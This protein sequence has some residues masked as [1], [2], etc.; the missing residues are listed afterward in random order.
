MLEAPGTGVPG[1]PPFVPLASLTGEALGALKSFEVGLRCIDS[2][3]ACIQGLAAAFVHAANTPAVYHFIAAI[4][5][6]IAEAA[7]AAAAAPAA[8]AAAAAAASSTTAAGGGSAQLVLLLYMLNDVLQRC[9]SCGVPFLLQLCC[10]PLQ[11]ICRA[12]A[13]AAAAD[14]DE[15]SRVISILRQRGTF[16]GPQI[17]DALL[18][19]LRGQQVDVPPVPRHLLLL[20]PHQQQHQHQQ[21][22]QQQQQRVAGA[23]PAEQADGRQVR[24]PQTLDGYRLHFPAAADAAAAAAAEAATPTTPE[25]AAFQQQL[26]RTLALVKDCTLTIKDAL[27]SRKRQSA[28]VAEL[29]QTLQRLAEGECDLQAPTADPSQQEQS[30]ANI[31]TH[32]TNAKARIA[33]LY[34]KQWNKTV[35]LQETFLLLAERIEERM[36]MALLRH[37]KCRELKLSIDRVLAERRAA[38]ANNGG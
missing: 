14:R 10:S 28:R 4:E 15:V 29:Q 21:P 1:A 37:A 30:E 32:L 8:A 20:Q 35:Q 23:R 25:D 9:C 17:C 16:G 31:Q 19:T 36:Q 3:S 18:R 22:L 5:R 26:Q 11:S 12:A 33:R 24:G 13:A 27:D 38:A 6:Q 34:E 2:S 7:A